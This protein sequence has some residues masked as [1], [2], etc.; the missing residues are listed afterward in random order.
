MIHDPVLVMRMHL[1]L[2]EAGGQNMGARVN[3]VQL[4]GLGEKGQS[5]CCYLA[6]GKALDIAFQGQSPFPRTQEINGSTGSALAYAKEQ[7]WVCS[8]DELEPGDLVFSVHPDGTPHHIAMYTGGLE[9]AT[10]SYDG[11][12]AGPDEIVVIAGNTSEDG[13]SSNGDR[14]AERPVPKAGKV[15]VKYP[16]V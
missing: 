10:S 4:W 1:H 8:I 7:N 13:I 5:W 2:R 12:A 11:V 14:V 9:V 16:R 15:G 6:I 3:G